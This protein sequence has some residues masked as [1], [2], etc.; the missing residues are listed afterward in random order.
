MIYTAVKDY[1]CAQGEGLLKTDPATLTK[2][3]V[4]KIEH[5]IEYGFS[6][7]LSELNPETQLFGEDINNQSPSKDS[8][9]VIDAISGTNQFIAGT[10]EY[11]LCAA[12]VKNGEIIYAIVVAPRHSEVFEAH[13]GQGVLYNNKP[14][15]FEK[16]IGDLVLN[17]DPS[18]KLNELQERV[19]K[20][21]FSLYP[22]I[23]NQSSVLSYCRVA[24]RRYRRIISISKDSFP[25]FA[26]TFILNEAEG[27]CTNIDM[28]ANISPDDR[29]FI[30]AVN[31]E[32]YQETLSIVKRP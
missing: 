17:L 10:S 32:V 8:Y 1:F 28:S 4:V 18:S 24:Q 31:E 16:S 2:E 26:G 11:A 30:G 3:M 15:E 20:L 19:W 22:F 5:D 13:K 6:K 7:L 14:L 12:E 27:V 23:L 25:Y 9:W 29:V 21:T